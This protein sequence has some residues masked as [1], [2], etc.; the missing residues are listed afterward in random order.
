MPIVYLIGAMFYLLYYWVYKMLL[1]KY[2][3]R[4]S[5]FSEDLP[6]NSLEYAEFGLILHLFIGSYMLSSR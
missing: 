2:Y 1:L 3:R 5:N 6:L 4:T